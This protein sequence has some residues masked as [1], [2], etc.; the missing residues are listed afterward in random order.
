MLNLNRMQRTIDG[1]LS[2]FTKLIATL[3]ANVEKLKTG[4]QENS[5]EIAH[6]EEQNNAYSDKIREYEALTAN[7]KGFLGKQ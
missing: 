6:L 7:V 3:E 1:L 5:E 4:I 2:V